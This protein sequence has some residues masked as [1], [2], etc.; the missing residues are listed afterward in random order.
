MYKNQHQN[1]DHESIYPLK[2]EK[3]NGLTEEEYLIQTL[4]CVSE[5]IITDNYYERNKRLIRSISD[6]LHDRHNRRGDMPPKLAGRV[7]EIFFVSIGKF[8]LR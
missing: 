2:Q 4:N 3:D 8:G 7:I 5:S 1:I 6:G